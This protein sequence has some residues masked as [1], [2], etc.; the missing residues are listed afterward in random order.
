MNGG[1]HT[2]CNITRDRLILFL[3]LLRYNCMRGALKLICPLPQPPGTENPRETASPTAPKI[4]AK[5]KKNR[6][7]EFLVCGEYARYN[8]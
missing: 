8:C 5:P 7:A 2:S 4:I 3:L 6:K 1:K